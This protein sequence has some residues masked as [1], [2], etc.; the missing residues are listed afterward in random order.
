[1]LQG[2]GAGCIVWGAYTQFWLL[3]GSCLV[4]L[5]LDGPCMQ[6]WIRETRDP[7]ACWMMDHF[8]AMLLTGRVYLALAP[9]P[10]RQVFSCPP[11]TSTI[12]TKT[13]AVYLSS[14]LNTQET[15]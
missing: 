8:S 15:S 1:M 3:A 2:Y 11:A 13:V 4:P 6:K 5:A 10:L 12:D 14:L 7:D 9:L